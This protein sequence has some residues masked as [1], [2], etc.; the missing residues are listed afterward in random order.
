MSKDV[1][2]EFQSLEDVSPHTINFIPGEKIRFEYKL[3]ALQMG[4]INF[5]KLELN[6]FDKFGLFYKTREVNNKDLVS[7][8]PDVRIGR[9]RID[10]SVQI[11]SLSSTTRSDPLGSACT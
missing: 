8:L 7:V 6:L 11:G 9:G 3:E 1:P 10:E 5:G 4:R 2:E